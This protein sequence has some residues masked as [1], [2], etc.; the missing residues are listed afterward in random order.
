MA[1]S[2]E[3]SLLLVVHQRSVSPWGPHTRLRLN[4]QISCFMHSCHR[5]TLYPPSREHVRLWT[6]AHEHRRRHIS[7]LPLSCLA[8]AGGADG[9]GSCGGALTFLTA[10]FT[11]EISFPFIFL[12]KRQQPD[13]LDHWSE[14]IGCNRCLCN[15]ELK[16][17]LMSFLG[18][19]SYTPAGK[20]SQLVDWYQNSSDNSSSSLAPAQLRARLAAQPPPVSSILYLRSALAKRDLT[21]FV[22]CLFCE[23]HLPQTR[24]WSCGK[25]AR[26][27]SVQRATTWRMRMDGSEAHQP[28]LR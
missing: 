5:R 17:A 21:V 25:S 15:L 7:R 9:W 24:R 20:C 23:M 10:I 3:R 16:T 1:S 11:A 8:A 27:T 12:N 19:G 2:A 26:G 14:K 18:G 28:S 13:K 22:A 6:E 4:F